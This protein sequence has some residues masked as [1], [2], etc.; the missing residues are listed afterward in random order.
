MHLVTTTTKFVL[1]HLKHLP[2]I[3]WLPGRNDVQPNN[4]RCGLAS[5]SK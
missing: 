5:A 1:V 3:S 4:S 2:E